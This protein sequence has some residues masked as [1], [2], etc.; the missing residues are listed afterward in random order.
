MVEN[1]SAKG[2]GQ[3]VGDTCQSA[4]SRQGRVS[5][6]SLFKMNKTIKMSVCWSIRKHEA[7]LTYGTGKDPRLMRSGIRPLNRC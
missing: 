3:P 2:L 1:T 5:L 7:F 4:E 6:S